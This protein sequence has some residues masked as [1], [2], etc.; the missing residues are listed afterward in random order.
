MGEDWARFDHRHRML[1]GWPVV[2]RAGRVASDVYVLVVDEE[3]CQR[4]KR[5]GRDED[6]PRF[7]SFEVLDQADLSLL[8]GIVIVQ[9]DD[10]LAKAAKAMSLDAIEAIDLFHGGTVAHIAAVGL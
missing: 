1:F 9:E 8:G 2:C 10:L 7:V 3:L 5:L 4:W 6:Q